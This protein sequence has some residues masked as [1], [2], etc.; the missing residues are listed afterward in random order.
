MNNWQVCKLQS[1]FGRFSTIIDKVKELD[2]SSSIQSWVKWKDYSHQVVIRGNNFYFKIYQQD[3]SN[4][5]YPRIREAIAKVYRRDFGLD[6]DILTIKTQSSIFQIQKR[7]PLRVMELGQMPFQDLLIRW[8]QALKLVQEELG[9]GLIAKQ[10]K[11]IDGYQDVQSIKLVRDCMNKFQD[12]ALTKDG[13]VILLDD[14]DWFL[15]MVDDKQRWLQKRYN[16]VQLQ[17]VL[18][19]R[20]MVPYSFHNPAFHNPAFAPVL[21][22]EMVNKWNFINQDYLSDPVPLDFVSMRQSQLAGNIQVLA[23]MK[24]LEDGSTKQIVQTILDP[25]RDE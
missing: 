9:L 25:N 10:L 16:L 8:G 20:L 2:G 4:D 18:G 22:R 23:K 13:S 3:L 17:T 11:L 14:A 6:W 21:A 1:G 12:Y 15:A 19:P 5:F 24:L 7:E